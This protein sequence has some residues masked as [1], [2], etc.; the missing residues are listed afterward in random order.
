MHQ[1]STGFALPRWRT[2]PQSKHVDILNG[3]AIQNYVDFLRGFVFFADFADAAGEGS[4]GLTGGRGNTSGGLGAA[5]LVATRFE[6][7][8]DDA[9]LLEAFHAIR[10][11]IAESLWRTLERRDRELHRLASKKLAEPP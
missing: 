1:C 9:E 5:R 8:F 10:E 2:L 4:T 3:F 6:K 7:K 11:I